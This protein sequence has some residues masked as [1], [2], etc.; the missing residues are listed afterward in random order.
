[1]KRPPFLDGPTVIS[2]LCGHGRSCGITSLAQT[3]VRRAKVIDRP[4]Q[5]H[6]VMPC[7][8]ATGQCAAS[9]RQR[10]QTF[11]NVAFSRSREAVWIT[12]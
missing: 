1:M 11:S 10:R 12:P 3:F 6:P 9:P 5:I 7:Q 8:R 4:D 2:K